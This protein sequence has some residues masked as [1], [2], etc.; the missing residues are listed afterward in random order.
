MTKV[1]KKQGFLKKDQEKSGNL[2]KFKKSQVLAVQIYKIPY[3][4]KP[5]SGKNQL[6]TL[7]SD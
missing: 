3:F 6:K 2:T 4:P 5:S 7:M 1:R